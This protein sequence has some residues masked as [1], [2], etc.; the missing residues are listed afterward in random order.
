[1][2]RLDRDSTRRKGSLEALLEEINQGQP[3]IIVGTQMLAKGHHFPKVSL[4]VIVDV[5]SA[6][7]SSDFRASE[8]LAQLLTQV[9]GR[10]GRGDIA[11]TVLLQTH[12]PGHP[13]LQDV[14]PE[15]LQLVCPQRFAGAS[16]NAFAA[17]STSG[18]VS[19][20]IF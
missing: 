9:A 12:Y 14:I 18:A 5:D 13:L 7:Y 19:Y 1:M 17:L 4:V 3:A 16:A 11:G 6:L 10:A 2:I 15:W 8:Q 20:R